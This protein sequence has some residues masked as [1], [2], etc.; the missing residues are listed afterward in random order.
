MTFTGGGGWSGITHADADKDRLDRLEVNKSEDNL[1]ITVSRS[2]P[3]V[4]S[5]INEDGAS[6]KVNSSSEAG[7]S[8]YK[9][10]GEGCC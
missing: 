2:F 3:A 10:D 1:C 4:I 8:R 9:F 6:F 5:R 7:S